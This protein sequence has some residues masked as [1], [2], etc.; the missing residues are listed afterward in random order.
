MPCYSPLHGYRARRPSASGKYQVVFNSRHGM[1]DLPMTVPCGQCIGCRLERSR[2]WAIRCVHEAQ[3]HD[4]NCFITLTYDERTIP[5]NNSLNLRHIQLFCKRLRKK[6]GK[7]R[8]FHAGEYGNSTYRPHYHMLLFGYRPR[9]L[10]HYKTSEIGHPL[11][12]SKLIDETWGLGKCFLGDVS[13]DSA[14]YVARYIMKKVTGEMAEGYYEG[15][16]PEYITMSRNKGIGESWL[17]RFKNDIYRHD[18]LVCN[19]KVM[20][21]P[22]AYDRRIE[23]TDPSLIEKIKRRRKVRA[24]VWTQEQLDTSRLVKLAQIQSLKRG[25]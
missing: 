2:Q 24:K 4:D 6:V 20:R 23:F 18:H 3:M 17:Q 10:R 7:F 16:K 12:T 22:R 13:F 15:R 25:L 11:Y 1:I 14:A 5:E 9:D 21:A 19:G 8:Y